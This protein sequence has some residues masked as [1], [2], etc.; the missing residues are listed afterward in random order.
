MKENWRQ[1]EAF[2]KGFI[3]SIVLSI[4]S[5]IICGAL[6]VFNTSYLYGALLGSSILLLSHLIIWV[7][8][9]RIPSIKSSMAAI[10]GYVAPLIRIVIYITVFLLVIFLVNDN[11][12]GLLM[13]TS[14][15][16]T[17]VLLIVYTIT[18]LS[19]GIVIVIDIILDKREVNK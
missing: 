2:H 5:I 3:V 10:T 13:V 14:P 7:L 6:C 17:F 18:P 15:I 4:V 9:Y 1:L 8:W 19:Y 11:T 16:N 12:T